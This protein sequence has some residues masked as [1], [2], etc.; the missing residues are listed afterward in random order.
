MNNKF[1]VKEILKF[2]VGGG[3]AVLV[4]A[5]VYAVLKQYIDISV[6]KAVSYILGA[7]VGFLINKF[8]TFDSK[9]F[10]ISEIGKYILLYTCSALANT[11]V[12][13]L[14]LWVIPSTVFAFLCATGTSTIMNFLGQKFF[15]FE[16]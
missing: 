1:D 9:Q 12:N 15:V 16:K 11:G 2:L 13:R 3:S 5:L 6:A 7:I 14:V 10:R 4:D 8:W